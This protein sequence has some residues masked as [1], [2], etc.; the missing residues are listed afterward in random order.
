MIGL[1]PLGFRGP[2]YF[3]FF[4]KKI[5][6]SNFLSELFLRQLRARSTSKNGVMCRQEVLLKTTR[7]GVIDLHESHGTF[8]SSLE[9]YSFDGKNAQS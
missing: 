5:F 8:L 4:E 9:N 6:F 7:M 3:F 1:R 2:K